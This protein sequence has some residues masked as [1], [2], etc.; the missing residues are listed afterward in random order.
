M[1]IRIQKKN[2]HQKSNFVAVSRVVLRFWAMLYFSGHI[3]ISIS[4]GIQNR[5]TGVYRACF[6]QWAQ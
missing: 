5:L 1:A 6:Q 2:M 4:M 3:H